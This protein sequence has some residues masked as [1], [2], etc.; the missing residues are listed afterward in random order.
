MDDNS[1]VTCRHVFK[2]RLAIHEIP[3]AR[4]IFSVHVVLIMVESV[5]VFLRETLGQN[6]EVNKS[7]AK[8]FRVVCNIQHV[9]HLIIL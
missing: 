3:A 8:S 2:E 5:L 9:E 1:G 4:W 7:C 6:E